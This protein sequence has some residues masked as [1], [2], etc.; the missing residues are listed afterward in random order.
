MVRVSDAL[1]SIYPQ[2]NT[3]D[4]DAFV[5][6]ALYKMCSENVDYMIVQENDRFIG[7]ITEHDIANK[8]LYTEKP[9]SMVPVRSFMNQCLPVATAD[10]TIEYCMQLME[11]YNIR[12]VAVYDEFT[13]KGIVSAQDLMR[14]TLSKR[15]AIFDDVKRD[16]YDWT[17]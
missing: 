1:A 4:P 15:T 10:N 13:F 2:F 3:I 6:D 14:F 17:Y 12:Y 9:L 5:S 11:R 16:E 7:I 8:V